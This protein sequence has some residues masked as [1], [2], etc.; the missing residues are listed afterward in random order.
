MNISVRKADLADTLAIVDILTAAVQYKLNHN[1]M[2]WGSEPFSEREVRGLIK[3]ASIFMAYRG[4]DLVATFGLDWEDERIW[5][6]QP[7]VAGY[8]HR[9]ATKNTVHGL[10]IGKAVIDWATAEVAKNGRQYLRLDS[11]ARNTKL[12]AYYEGQ[13]FKLVSKKLIPSHKDYYAN[14]YERN[15]S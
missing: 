11:D 6:V 12:C 15:V 2:S 7:P 4:K 13:G 9:L 1:D 5:G 10:G 3:T 14:L 8:I